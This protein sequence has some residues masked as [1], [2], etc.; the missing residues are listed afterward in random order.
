[1][2]SEGKKQ[3][4]ARGLTSGRKSRLGKKRLP[5]EGGRSMPVVRGVFLEVLHNTLRL[6]KQKAKIKA[7]EGG[8]VQGRGKNVDVA[9]TMYQKL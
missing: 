6:R 8:E 2:S 1:M 5:V 7:T 4:K 3:C 9:Y